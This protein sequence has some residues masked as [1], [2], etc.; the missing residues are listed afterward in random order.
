MAKVAQFRPIWSHWVGKTDTECFSNLVMQISFS[1]SLSLSLA[2]SPSK[3]FSFGASFLQPSS[4]YADLERERVR[5]ERDCNKVCSFS[6][7]FGFLVFHP[8]LNLVGV[9]AINL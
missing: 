9:D 3:T 5:E 4:K 6:F 1:L 2:C 8:Q 7:N